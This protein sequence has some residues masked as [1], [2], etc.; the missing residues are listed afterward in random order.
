MDLI[1]HPIPAVIV[2]LGL[3]VFFHEAGH[4]VVGRLCGIAVDIFSIGFGPKIVGFEVRG[5]KYQLSWIPLGGFVK[6]YGMT[7]NEKVPEGVSGIAFREASLPKRMAT[8]SAGP[9]ANLI[10]AFVAY[11][12]LGMSGVP[13]APAIIGTIQQGSAAEEAGFEFLDKV[14]SINGDAIEDWPDMR[15][16][17]T[18]SPNKPLDVVVLREGEEFNI[19]LI[20]AAVEAKDIMGNQVQVGRA[21]IANGML[22]SVVAV[23]ERNSEA[24]KAGIKT[25]DKITAIKRD[26]EWVKVTYWYNLVVY[27]N[28]AI[29]SDQA[30]V[31]L[32]TED[33]KEIKLNLG[34]AE[35]ISDLG[36]I[37]AQLVVDKAESPSDSVL[38]TGDRLIKWGSTELAEIFKL[39]ELQSNN[40]KPQVQ[41]TI[42][43]GFDV[44]N[45]QVPMEQ[46]ERQLPSGKKTIYILAASFMGNLIEPEREIEK[47]D[48]LGAAIWYG[49]SE[50]AVKTTFLAKT[51]GKLISGNVP[52]KA[53]GGPMMIAKVAGDAA[54]AGWQAFLETLA[55]I[56]VNLAVLNMFPIPVLDGGQ[57]VLLGA[58]GIRRKKLSESAIENF[59]KIGFVMILALVVLATYNDL[60]RFWVSMLKSVSGVFQ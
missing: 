38:K 2:L 31:E 54:K 19:R 42:Q 58:E 15:D 51:L 55:L 35:D 24:H 17:I 48:S 16:I 23:T 36:L 44:I 57:L 27:I 1:S 50:T 28:Q 18:K 26:G 11:T 14:V 56:S 43:R 40:I 21:G 37:D 52:L 12:I 29:A 10:L 39:G 9:I 22:S 8:V 7:A 20:P 41:F 46:F 45:V 6:F 25:G 53:L 30:L 59:Q 33:A 13:H 4:F 32:R 34:S 47:Y 60:S 3:L 49:M 5:V